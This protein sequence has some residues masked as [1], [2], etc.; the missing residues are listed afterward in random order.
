MPIKVSRGKDKLKISFAYSKERVE[1]IR[2]LDDRIWDPKQEVWFAA[3]TSGN[4]TKLKEFFAQDELIFIWQKNEMSIDELEKKLQL[5]GYT[6]KTQE[7]YL[8]QVNK[9]LDWFDG[10]LARLEKQDIKD[11]IIWLKE[12]ESLSHSF[13]NQAISAIKFLALRVLKKGDLTEGIPRLKKEKKLPVVLSEKEVRRILSQPKNE[14][15]KTMLA[16]IYSSGL[17]VGEVVRLKAGDIDSDRMLLRV[18]QGK[19][20]K[21]RYT[22]LSENCL[23]QVRRY[24]KLYKPEDWLFPGAKE[25]SHLT[26]RTVQ[27]VFK[28]ACK[29][30]NINKDVSVHSLRHS[31]ATHL[32]EHGT[33]LRYIQKLLGH[34]SSTTTEV[35]THVSKRDIAKIRSPLDKI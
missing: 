12:E 11:Y 14:K 8:S 30:A 26:E 9:L 32:L 20:R 23:K 25:G 27:R 13:I 2:K 6:S 31:F 7:V 15:H 35:Y 10:E 5:E 19:G 4:L 21:D 16:L 3:N 22:L 34:K 18:K 17:R 33:D 29:K 28:Q 24:Y 1:K